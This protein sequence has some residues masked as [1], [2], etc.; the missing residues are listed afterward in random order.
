MIDL[1]NEIKNS[2]NEVLNFVKG[3]LQEELIAQGHVLTGNLRDSIDGIIH[4]A[5]D[6]I[7]GFI[8]IE[9]Y[10]L[11]VDKGVKAKK[12]P[13]KRGSGAKSSK[14]IAA[15]IRFFELRGLSDKE[16]RSA[17]FATANVHKREGMPTYRSSRFSSNGKRTGFITETIESIGVEVETIMLE[18]I[19]KNVIDKLYQSLE[20]LN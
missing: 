18:S 14:Y 6:F 17:A 11:I 5:G 8:E 9:D 15:L 13:Y 12:I 16:A 1:D 7:I 20:Q 10:G 3:K 4:E 19:S 2:I